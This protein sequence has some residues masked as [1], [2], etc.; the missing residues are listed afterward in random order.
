MSLTIGV[1]IGGTKTAAGVV[2]EDGR[3]V[4]TIVAP[5]PTKDAAA[6]ERSIVALV[7]E[8]AAAHPVDAVGVGAAARCA[9]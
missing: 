4:A 5:T 6:T 2:T 3:I 8:L 7:A 9:Q 1:D